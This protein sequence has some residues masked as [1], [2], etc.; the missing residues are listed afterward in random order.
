[1]IRP[2][3]VIPGA[4]RDIPPKNFVQA[5]RETYGAKKVRPVASDQD[6]R[7]LPSASAIAMK[8]PVFGKRFQ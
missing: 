3:V 8:S 6:R 2:P 5:D 7:V 4:R 1:M